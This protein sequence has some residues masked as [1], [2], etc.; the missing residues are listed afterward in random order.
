MVGRK[1]QRR[2]LA[3]DGT[4]VRLSVDHLAYTARALVSEDTRR[5][6]AHDPD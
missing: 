5:A 4:I 6:I 3:I 2:L 1:R